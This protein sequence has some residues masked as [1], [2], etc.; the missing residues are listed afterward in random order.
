LLTGHQVSIPNDELARNDVE[1]V[2]RRPHIRKIEDIPLALDIA[3]DKAARAVDIVSEMLKDHEGMEP[4]YPPRVFLSDVRRDC[5]NLRIIYWYHPPRYWDFAD[6]CDRIIRKIL[7][8]F[9][10]EGIRIAR[11]AMT[12]YVALDGEQ[13]LE[14]RNS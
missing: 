11:P 7:E 1:N 10:A 12:S 4:Q 5:I 6:F 8:A 2:G 3:P 9:A 14:I 13:P